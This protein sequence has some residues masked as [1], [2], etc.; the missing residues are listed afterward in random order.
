MMKKQPWDTSDTQE[1][2]VSGAEIHNI[3]L[4]S[5]THVNWSTIRPSAQQSYDPMTILADQLSSSLGDL[6]SVHLL[7][8][9]LLAGGVVL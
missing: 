6:H 4:D 8:E 3:S 2:V 7:H 5:Y 9:L 1:K